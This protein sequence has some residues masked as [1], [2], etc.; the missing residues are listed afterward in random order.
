MSKKSIDPY[1][2]FSTA[3]LSALPL[4]VGG[5]GGDRHWFVSPSATAVT[6]R[7]DAKSTEVHS[8]CSTGHFYRQLEMRAPLEVRL[9]IWCRKS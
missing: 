1:L 7:V 3:L 8:T 5:D 4:V 2:S 9:W 6:L